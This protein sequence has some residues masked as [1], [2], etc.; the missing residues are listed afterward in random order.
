MVELITLE[1]AKAH[2]YII[3]NADDNDL[4]L[5]IYAASEAVIDYLK[6]EGVKKFIGADG[7]LLKNEAGEPVQVPFKVK[8]AT[9]LMLG[10]LHKDR[11]DNPGNAFEHGYLPKPVTALLYSM[12]DP[13]LR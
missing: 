8:A 10:Y 2:L 12:R 11:D 5:K 9:L 7:E 4:K 13:A 1:E 3:H 6:A